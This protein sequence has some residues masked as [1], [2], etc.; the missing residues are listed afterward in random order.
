[1]EFEIVNGIFIWPLHISRRNEERTEDTVES[2]EKWICGGGSHWR[3][4]DLYDRMEDASDETKYAEFVYFHPFVQRL[5]Y[6]R[7]LEKDRA[8]RLLKRDDVKGV[9]ISLSLD[10]NEKGGVTHEIELGVPRVHLYLFHTHVALLIVE[11]ESRGALDRR[12]VLELMERLR[13][14]YAPFW[15][16]D[17]PG[18][19]PRSVEWLSHEGA[20]IARSDYENKLGA[21]S[22]TTKERVSPV[23]AH[24]AELLRPLERF[25]YPEENDILYFRQVGDARIPALFFLGCEAPE[26]ISEGDF[27]RIAFLDEN[28][29]PAR[30]PYSAPFLKDFEKD[31]CYDRF[32][33]PAAG[34]RTRYLCSGYGFVVVTDSRS[35]RSSMLQMHFR[36]HYFQIGLIAH[37][38]RASLLVFSDRLADKKWDVSK[39]QEEIVYFVSRFWFKEISSEVQAGDLF[40]WWS[41]H[42]GTPDLFQQVMNEKRAVAELAA[43]RRQQR[44]TNIVVRL[45]WITVIGLPFLIALALIAV[46]SAFSGPDRQ[47]AWWV[48]A[49]ALIIALVVA[50]IWRLH[51]RRKS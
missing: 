13:H 9:R 5:L 4:T 24:W 17:E 14:A 8:V 7:P 10:E 31:F 40:R 2:W 35:S 44:Q 30:K 3:P 50:G 23:A 28:G 37:F 34:F 26:K 15:S 33:D 42:L 12:I 29:D 25:T 46:L 38:Q 1:M 48:V 36:H 19:C 51:D 32:W 20:T 45:T 41:R 18:F 49:A 11:V 22:V 43:A 6:P 47:R 16:G 21:I 27:V 39:L